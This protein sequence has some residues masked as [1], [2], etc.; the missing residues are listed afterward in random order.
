MSRELAQPV[1]GGRRIHDQRIDSV[2]MADSANQGRNQD[3]VRETWRD[4]YL[5][6][7][8]GSSRKGN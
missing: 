4:E 2:G 6:K 5:S 3:M 7:L 8:E 1:V